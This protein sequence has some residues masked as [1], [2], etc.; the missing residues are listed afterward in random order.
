VP[1]Y[2]AFLRAINVGGRVVRMEELRQVFAGCGFTDVETFIASGNVIFTSPPTDTQ[3]LE[4]RIGAALQKALGYAV[5]TFVR[6][7]E[8]LAAIA[9]H[10]PCTSDPAGAGGAV[11]IIFVAEPLNAAERKELA[12]LSAPGDEFSSRG[13]EVYW[14][15]F[16]KLSESPLFGKSLG[17]GLGSGTMRNRNTVVR[18]LGRLQS[19]APA[20]AVKGRRPRKELS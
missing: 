11:H 16:G 10:M 15:R 13:R 20:P 7:P 14:C 3:A 2:A 4:R 19:A 17:K 1:K 12:A 6:T 9:A 18:L 5:A 8:E